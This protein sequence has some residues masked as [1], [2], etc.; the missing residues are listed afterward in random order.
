M[1]T[2]AELLEEFERLEARERPEEA[3]D[4]VAW[5][6]ERRDAHLALIH[7]SPTPDRIADYVAESG[8][9]IRL[10]FP[11]PSALSAFRMRFYNLR[12]QQRKLR[13]KT[14]GLEPWPSE[15]VTTKTKGNVLFFL[16][17]TQADRLAV[18]TAEL[19]VVSEGEAW[20]ELGGTER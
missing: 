7:A 6:L 15:T 18:E 2:E 1:K 9:I 20:K 12:R 16:P 10:K 11:N 8:E 5:T 13:I 19:S 3:S 14:G 4:L 17:Q